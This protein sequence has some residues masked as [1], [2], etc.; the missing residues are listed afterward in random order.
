MSKGTEAGMCM[1]CKPLRNSV[2]LERNV[3]LG[4]EPEKGKIWIK[5]SRTLDVG[6]EFGLNLVVK[7]GMKNL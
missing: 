3:H 6:K 4:N 1:A 7:G 2:F 5:G